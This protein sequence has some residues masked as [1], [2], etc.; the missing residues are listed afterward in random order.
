[1]YCLERR[2]GTSVYRNPSACTSCVQRQE[3]LRR[4]LQIFC[5]G[6]TFPRIFSMLVLSATSGEKFQCNCA[7]KSLDCTGGNSPR[8]TPIP[9][10]NL[11]Q[12]ARVLRKYP[13][14]LSL[15]HHWISPSEDR[16]SSPGSPCLL[17]RIRRCSPLH[18]RRS[19][20]SSRQTVSSCPAARG[21]PGRLSHRHLWP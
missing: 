15:P 2:S 10:S 1:M 14:A 7:Y 21:S 18:T 17:C 9:Q 20:L 11:A 12:K 4:P 13:P 6:Q 3:G 19:A 5:R 8:C 16:A